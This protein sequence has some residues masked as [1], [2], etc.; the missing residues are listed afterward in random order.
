MAAGTPNLNDAES[1]KL[2]ELIEST[3]IWIWERPD[4]FANPLG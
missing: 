2:E 3:I 1:R 4:R